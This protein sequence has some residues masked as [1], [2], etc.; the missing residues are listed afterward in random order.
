MAVEQIRV[1]VQGAD[2]LSQAGLVAFLQ[3]WPELVVVPGGRPDQAQVFVVGIERLTVDVVAMLRRSA[4]EVGVPVILVTA[5]LDE[6]DLLVAVECRVVAVLPRSTVTADRLAYSVKAA[7]EGGAV[8]AP[9]LVGSLLKHI[10]RLHKSVLATNGLNASGL[11]DREIEVLRLM[12]DGFDTVEIAGKLSVSE[13][14]VKNIVY[15]MTRR[16][17]L[18]NRSHAVAYALRTGII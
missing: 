12:A 14:T 18:R 8:M 17:D 10:E 13:R 15:G 11:N 1:A 3:P 4:K 5:A 6:S 7:A 16:L 9:S 2:P